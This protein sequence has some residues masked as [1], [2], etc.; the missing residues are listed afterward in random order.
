MA[1]SLEID[2]VNAELERVDTLED[3]LDKFSSEI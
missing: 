3:E 1:G 2:Q